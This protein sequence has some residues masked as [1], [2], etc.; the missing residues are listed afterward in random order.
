MAGNYT[1]VLRNDTHKMEHHIELIVKSSPPE[2]PLAT[3]VPQNLEELVVGDIARFYCE[4]FV[5]NLG[6]PDEK[7]EISWHRVVGK[8]LQKMQSVEIVKR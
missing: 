5:G 2:T 1:C 6:L 4:A 7:S 8:Q 3:F